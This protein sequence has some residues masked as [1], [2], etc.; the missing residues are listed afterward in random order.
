MF[1]NSDCLEKIAGSIA[2]NP[3]AK[4]LSGILDVSLGSFCLRDPPAAFLG[5]AN[6]SLRLVKSFL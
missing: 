3:Y 6:L 4:Y 1:K 2:P 5:L